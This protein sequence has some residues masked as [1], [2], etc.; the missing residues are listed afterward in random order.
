MLSVEYT[1]S[2]S[3]TKVVDVYLINKTGIYAVEEKWEDSFA[4]QPING[5]F[6]NGFSV[7]KINKNLGK[8]WEYWFIQFN[9]F[10]IWIDGKEVFDQPEED[11]HL[12]FE[13]K[14]IPVFRLYA[15]W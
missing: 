7:K 6:E 4:G 10:N 11:G 1:H 3:L 13:I 15:G 14:Q 8:R 5:S 2:V 12:T 9:N